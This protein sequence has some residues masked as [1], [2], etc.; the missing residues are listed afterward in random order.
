VSATGLIAGGG[1]LPLQF[2][3]SA[4]EKKEKVITFGI[5]GETGNA[6]KKISEE[7]VEV[8]ITA[9][10]SIIKECKVRG[11][12]QVL[13]LGYVRHTNL[14]KNI[15]FDLKSLS[16]IARL[17][18]FTAV[19]VMGGIIK[20]FEKDGIKVLPST[21]LMEDSLAGKGNIS[22]RKPDK[23]Q[24]SDIN[25]GYKTAR[26]IAAMDAGQTVV[27]KKGGIIALEA[28]EGTDN[29]I[30]RGGALAGQ[31]FVVVKTA[32]PDQDM[33]YDVPVVGLKTLKTIKALNGAGIAVEAGKTFI[34]E[35]E[36]VKQ[37]AKNNGLFIYG[38]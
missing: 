29:C 13:F 30:K 8:N 3:K 32:R 37:Y 38:A 7:Y 16:V 19:Q 34:L 26:Q 23:K 6:I 36:K 35:P 31:G 14:F 2:L 28:Q 9:L 24:M 18:G 33:R 27:I 15:K 25:F 22:V 20:Q 4:A 12:K 21:H 1:S 11:V 10:S 17:K 5:A